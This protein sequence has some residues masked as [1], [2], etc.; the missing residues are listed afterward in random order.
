MVAWRARRERWRYV[1]FSS[2]LWLA[3]RFYVISTIYGCGGWLTW[4]F[5]L[6]VRKTQNG[7]KHV[8]TERFYAWEDAVKLAEKDPEIV[9][10]EKGVEYRPWSGDQG[11]EES[12]LEDE[13][14]TVLKAAEAEGKPSHETVDPSIPP[15]DGKG[16]QAA[17]R[18]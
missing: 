12:L 18:V 5:S 8:L 3:S 14:E 16:Q 15:N 1:S 13:D 6:Q 10:T 9:F 4:H 2:F 17:L 11:H 7:I